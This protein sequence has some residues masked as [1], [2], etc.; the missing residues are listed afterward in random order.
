VS[1]LVNAHA[2]SCPCGAAAFSV[3]AKPLARFYCHCLICQGVY[4][5]PF[6]DVTAF[7]A[8]SEH[9]RSREAVAFKRYRPPPALQRATCR[10]CG[11]PVLG[12]LRLAPF[13]R[14]LFVPTKNLKPGADIP[15]PSTHIFYHRRLHDATDSL[16]K[17]SGYWHSEFAVTKLV[18]IGA[19]QGDA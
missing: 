11:S 17:V 9:L 13:L 16:P 18:L 6:A 10:A 2:S 14:L 7:W 8:G 5:A 4:K 3:R 15:A 1:T 19:L 12:Y